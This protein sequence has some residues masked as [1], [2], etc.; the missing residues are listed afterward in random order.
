MTYRDLCRYVKSAY[1]GGRHARGRWII[2]KCLLPYQRVT[3][4]EGRSF[5]FEHAI[6]HEVVRA[7]LRTK[8]G[9]SNVRLRADGEASRCPKDSRQ[10]ICDQKSMATN[11]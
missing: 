9:R 6:D 11:I 1:G 2:F 4:T 7:E 3:P 8:S 10:L 5:C